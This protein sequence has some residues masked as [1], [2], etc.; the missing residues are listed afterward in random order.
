MNQDK[1]EVEWPILRSII[2]IEKKSI[3]FWQAHLT[4][5][6]SI[7]PNLDTLVCIR[8]TTCLASVW[9]ERG[10]SAMNLKSKIRN[11]LRTS[12]LDDL[13]MINLNGP[14]LNSEVMPALLEKV[15]ACWIDIRARNVKK[16]HR[17]SRPR[18]ITK[19]HGQQCEGSEESEHELGSDDQETASEDQDTAGSEDQ[20]TA[21][22]WF[23]MLWRLV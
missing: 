2:S 1:C 11:S 3:E 16:S 21:E 10:F 9:C 14:R 12:L 22:N 19:E 17:E 8:L 18:P 6:H 20:E 15:Y 4:M 13:I 23:H 7:T 5:Q